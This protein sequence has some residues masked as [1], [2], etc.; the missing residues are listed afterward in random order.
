M[1]FF[2]SIMD[3]ETQNDMN[4]K[5]LIIQQ[6]GLDSDLDCAVSMLASALGKCNLM[7]SRKNYR[8]V[9][10]QDEEIDTG[11]KRIR[12]EEII[13]EIKSMYTPLP[14]DQ[15]EEGNNGMEV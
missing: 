15:T 8:A 13:E 4:R 9:L 3:I 12:L 7:L 6:R 1:S 14:E 5:L 10:T 11:V 2:K